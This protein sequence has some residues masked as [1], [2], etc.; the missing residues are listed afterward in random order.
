MSFCTIHGYLPYYLRSYIPV[1]LLVLCS[2]QE[3]KEK[4]WH[5]IAIACMKREAGFH[6]KSWPPLWRTA[7]A[8]AVA[9]CG[10]PT[11]EGMLWKGGQP[12]GRPGPP[13][14]KGELAAGSSDRSRA[15]RWCPT[16]GCC[17]SAHGWKL[18]W[19]DGLGTEVWMPG[20][21]WRREGERERDQSRR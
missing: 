19:M 1:V 11:N 7:L 18:E 14:G 10:P 17:P 13:K 3:R 5:S 9:S 21:P 6:V 15:R 16:A 12:A 8:S 2:K 20:R 4:A